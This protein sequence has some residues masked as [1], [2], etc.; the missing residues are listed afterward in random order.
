MRINCLIVEDEK[1][2]QELLLS[3][4]REL[5]PDIEVVGIIDSFR[6]AVAFLKRY[7]IDIVFLDNHIKG[8]SGLG[9]LSQIPVM[10]FQVIF[11]TA[12]TEYAIEALNHGAVYYLLKPFSKEEFAT[13]VKKALAK[14]TQFRGLLVIG[15]GNK[16][17]IQLDQ[18]MYIESEGAYTFFVLSNKEKEISSRNLGS[19]E[20]KLPA[21]RFFRIHHSY[22]VNINYIERVERG[23]SLF[24]QL[25]DG[26]TR[27]PISQRRSKAFFE[28]L[29]KV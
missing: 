16:K 15:Q 20:D 17:A 22:I 9:V 6:E 18:L 4:L 2:S 28:H 25:T 13:G 23:E 26:E 27:L 12:Y 24:V 14:V 29:G 21:D 19:F 1:S 11:S 5:F 7:R 10:N 8:G 3:R